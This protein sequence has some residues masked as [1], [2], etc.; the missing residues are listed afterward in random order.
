MEAVKATVLAVTRRAGGVV[1]RV[2]LDEQAACARCAE[3]RGCGAGLFGAG[4]RSSEFEV[5][6]TSD[7]ILAAGD[8]VELA[9]ARGTLIRAAALAYALPLAGAAGATLVAGLFAA[10]DLVAVLAA[11]AGL[12][13]A[14]VGAR[15]L[16]SQPSC[17]REIQARPAAD[18]TAVGH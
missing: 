1:A 17:L 13:A 16:R 18:R 15:R 8:R 12:V 5:P 3:G 9:A 4:R 10:G 14:T 7:W 11:L 2:R 6:V